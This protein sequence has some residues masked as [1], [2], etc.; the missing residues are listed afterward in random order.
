MYIG[1]KWLLAFVVCFF[2][3]LPIVIMD[4]RY[5]VPFMKP[6]GFL[7]GVASLAC[8]YMAYLVEENRWKK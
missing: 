7:L 6:L 2:F 8:L 1:D 5:E 3:I 4:V